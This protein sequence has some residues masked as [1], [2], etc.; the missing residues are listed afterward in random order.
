MCSPVHLPL[1]L[2][3]LLQ[4]TLLKAV[5]GRLQPWTGEV[6]QGQGVKLGECHCSLLGAVM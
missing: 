3:L 1:L 4:S 2:L 6:T 5:A